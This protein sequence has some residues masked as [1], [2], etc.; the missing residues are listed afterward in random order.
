MTH[1]YVKRILA[2]RVYD[3]A[4]ETP[5]T[6]APGLSQRLHNRLH[7]KREDLQSVFS[8][9]LRGA[10]NKM[11][12]L[13]PA[14]LKNGVVCASAGNHAQ[15]VA[16]AATKL[17]CHALAVM[18]ETTPAVKIDAVRT[19]GG[20]KVRIVLH[21]TSYTDAC[22]HAHQLAQ[23]LQMTF[24]HPFDDPDV[25]AGQGTVGMEILRQHPAPLHAIFVA[26][27]GGGL[28]G[29][30]GAW[31]KE[32]RPDIRVIGVQAGDSNAM[33]RSLAAGRRVALPE[34]GLFSDGTAVRMV[35]EETFRLARRVVDEI[36]IVDTDEICAAIRDVFEDTR[37][38]LEPAGAL[39]VAG[40]KAYVERAARSGQSMT[41]QD[42]VA[43][44]C[45][46]N[47][48]FDRIGF[49]AERAAARQRS[50]GF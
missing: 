47:M 42:L 6:L 5:L 2:A 28:I 19:L 49:V 40:T 25:I 23:Q 48:N 44:A 46:A 24:V 43:V 9:K 35:G 14:Q 50:I 22:E 18:P 30:I 39:S 41:G 8:F 11:V 34:V 31:V 32:V 21:G 12:H 10:Y 36:V 13:S 17:G 33:A 27:G 3:V 16:L 26:V 20:S 38:I 37:C 45:G 15:G 29:G 4:V 7:L 1:D